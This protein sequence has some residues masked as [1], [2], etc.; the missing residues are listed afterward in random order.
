M[1]LLA[2]ALTLIVEVYGASSQDVAYQKIF[3]ERTNIPF[4]ILSD[5]HFRLTEALKLP[6]FTYNGVR[7]IGRLA[8]LVDKGKVEKVFY[9]VF[10]P[11]KN[12][13]TVL[14]WVKAC[15]LSERLGEE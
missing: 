5:K 1:K 12:A 15:T 6:T 14:E 11:D 9:P 7:L 13:E 10:P 3:V 4:E 8:L 2:I